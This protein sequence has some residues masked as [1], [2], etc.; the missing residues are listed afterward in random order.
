MGVGRWKIDSLRE[1]RN[2]V[3]HNDGSDPLFIEKT[4][5]LP[6]LLHV[7][8]LLAAIDSNSEELKA[9]Q[10]IICDV[11]PGARQQLLRLIRGKSA[12]SAP[13]GIALIT[14]TLVVWLGIDHALAPRISVDTVT[15]GTVEQDLNK[16]S[17]LKRELSNRLR[18]DSIWSHW[19]GRRVDVRL[20]TAKSYPEANARLREHKWDVAFGYSPVVS[21]YM[22]DKGYKAA[23]VMFPTEPVYSTIFF[24]TKK[25]AYTSLSSVSPLTRLALGDTFSASKYY[26]PLSMLWGRSVKLLMDNTTTE[27]ISLVRNK[28]ADIGV[29][30]GQKE[31]FEAN[32]PDLMV[33]GVSQLLPQSI[34]GISPLV[35]NRDALVMRDLLLSMPPSVRGKDQ[36]NFGAGATPDYRKFRRTIEQARALSACIRDSHRGTQLSCA[37]AEVRIVEGWID[38]VSP[39]GASI[40]IEGTTASKKE[41]VLDANRDVVQRILLGQTLAS[42]KG[43]RIKA[44]VLSE[45]SNDG[46][47]TKINSP[48]QLELFD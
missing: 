26:V 3:S 22:L 11:H 12:W 47:R 16:Y 39:S 4:V 44:L 17:G 41:F 14:T 32:H 46:V 37:D 5:A 38:D 10:R 40:L 28:K 36:A 9:A 27:I 29:I 35:S 19:L 8:A 2:R 30:A 24:T 43:R 6:Y 31:K 23:G 48:N 1:F 34:F 42:L 33:I 45:K 13:F 25:S 21:I 18:V 7:K 20:E 15:V